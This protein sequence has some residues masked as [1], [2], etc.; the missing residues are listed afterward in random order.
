MTCFGPACV[1]PSQNSF[2][3][4]CDPPRLFAG[5]KATE[6]NQSLLGSPELVCKFD[7]QVVKSE[8]ANII[9]RKRANS[10]GGQI[11]HT[12]YPQIKCVRNLSNAF[13]DY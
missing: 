13:K 8:S 7:N 6:P 11:L 2:V 4:P 1:G 5:D 12:P 3:S 10:V 9:E